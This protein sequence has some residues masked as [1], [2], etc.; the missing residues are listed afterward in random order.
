MSAVSN[1]I[2][3]HSLL[4]E[5]AMR[6]INWTRATE[7]IKKTPVLDVSKPFFPKGETIETTPLKY[8]IQHGKIETISAIRGHRTWDRVVKAETG[9]ATPSLHQAVQTGNPNIVKAVLVKDILVKEPHADLVNES[10][11]NLIDAK[12]KTALHL[13][14]EMLNDGLP[15]NQQILEHLLN[16]GGDPLYVGTTTTR[17]NKKEILVSP[18]ELSLNN[19]KRNFQRLLSRYIKTT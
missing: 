17:G 10:F 9:T 5:A 11:T 1:T 8:A 14:T 2:E 12:G 15:Q 4:Q 18:Y 16:N 3:L 19:G 7:F 6:E 13:A